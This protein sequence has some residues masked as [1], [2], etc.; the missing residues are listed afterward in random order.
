VKVVRHAHAL[1]FA[2]LFMMEETRWMQMLP[3][4]TMLPTL[5]GTTMLAEA[6]DGVTGA[7][8]AGSATAT[9]LSAMAPATAKPRMTD[10]IR[11]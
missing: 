7:A 9:V 11:M 2:L 4:Q 1:T 3:P 10:F 8:L 6:V 5:F